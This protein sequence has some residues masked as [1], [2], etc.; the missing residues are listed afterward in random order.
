MACRELDSRVCGDR[1]MK[2]YLAGPMRGYPAF[3]YPA[4]HAAANR[5]RILGHEVFS[6]AERDIERDNKDW[7]E[8]SPSGDLAEAETKGFSLRDALGD[9]LN[10]ICR[11]AEGVAMM[12]GWIH[13]KGAI[14]EKATAEALGLKVI[15]L[16]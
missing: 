10:Y 11:E 16:E 9:D 6:P 7:G 8:I 14:A 4:F 12:P 5:L 2:L 3:N 13:S 1:T 15:I